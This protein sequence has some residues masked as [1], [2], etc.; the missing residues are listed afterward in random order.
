MLYIQIILRNSQYNLIDKLHFEILIQ[1]I[2]KWQRELKKLLIINY[3]LLINSSL[4][5]LSHL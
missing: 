2:K 4:Y 5:S 1:F 3:Q